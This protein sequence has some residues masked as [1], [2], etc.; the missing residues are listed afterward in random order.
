MGWL[1]R[2]FA[3]DYFRHRQCI[4]DDHVARPASGRFGNRFSLDA[5]ASAGAWESPIHT[6]VRPASASFTPV[7]KRPL[8]RETPPKW[9]TRFSPTSLATAFERPGSYLAYIV[10]EDLA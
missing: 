6:A 3:H 9:N 1:T 8:P 5:S 7:P 2:V 4:A 10:Q